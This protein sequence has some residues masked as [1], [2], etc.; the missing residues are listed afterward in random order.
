LDS[1]RDYIDARDFALAIQALVENQPKQD[2]YNIG[3]GKSTSN[4]ELIDLLLKYS[5]LA[6]RP[7]IIEA[8]DRPEPKVAAKAD[9]NRIHSEL[10]WSPSIPLEETIKDIVNDTTER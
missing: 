10:G 2:V 6:K 1:R 7:E 8:M 9:I 4:Q 3:S 5:Q